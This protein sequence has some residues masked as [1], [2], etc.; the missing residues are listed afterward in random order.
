MTTAPAFSF[1]TPSATAAS[2]FTT[3]AP[4]SF[5][6][7]ATTTAPTSISFLPVTATGSAANTTLSNLLTQP[8][9]TTTVPTIVSTSAIPSSTT[10]TTG[11]AATIGFGIPAATTSPITLVNLIA[12]LKSNLFSLFCLVKYT[13][14][15]YSNIYY[16]SRWSLCSSINNYINQYVNDWCQ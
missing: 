1:E 15:H 8:I 5:I 13:N 10:T 7:P 6:P 16:W 4:I 3:I 9:T 14:T 11:A 12:S 2:T